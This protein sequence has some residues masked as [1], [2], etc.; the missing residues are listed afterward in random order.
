MADKGTLD[1]RIEELS[2]KLNETMLETDIN[3]PKYL[4]NTIN[5]ILTSVKDIL[6]FNCVEFMLFRNLDGSIPKVG[7]IVTDPRKK[8]DMRLHWITGIGYDE[9]YIKDSTTKHG[10]SIICRVVL[11]YQ[12]SIQNLILKIYFFMI[13]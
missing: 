3:N 2:I 11:H 9:G 13:I 7:E 12:Y 10:I 5:L 1:S 8:T 6:N 4:E